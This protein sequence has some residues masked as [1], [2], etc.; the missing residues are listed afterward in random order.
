VS[1]LE[2]QHIQELRIVLHEA[3]D[4]FLDD[5]VGNFFLNDQVAVLEGEFEG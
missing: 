2:H 5:L 4:P 1:I 3:Y